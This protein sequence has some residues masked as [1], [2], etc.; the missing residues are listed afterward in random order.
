MVES[1]KKK[2]HGQWRTIDNE[3]LM[4]NDGRIVLATH[5]K[6]SNIDSRKG[7]TVPG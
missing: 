2:M 4:D 6:L 3:E 1:K 5:C 7:V